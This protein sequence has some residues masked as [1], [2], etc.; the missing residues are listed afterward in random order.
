MTATA[1]VPRPA[2]GDQY[3][4]R[5]GDATAV[6]G[7]VAAVLREFTKAGV[8]YTETWPDEL[9]PPMGC[10]IVMAPWPNRIEDGR[11][12]DADGHEQQLDITEPGRNCA[13]HGLLRNVAFQPAVVTSDA[14][15]LAAPVPPQHGY[16][17]NLDVTV[18]YQLV[19]EGLRV[20]HTVTNR[21]AAPAPF[22]VGAHPYLRIGDVPVE[23]LTLAVPAD[24]QAPIDERW[25]PIGLAPV[26]QHG[27]DLRGA[28]RVLGEVNCDIALTDIAL[29]S[30]PAGDRH[31]FVLSAPDGRSLTLWSDPAFGW[32][33]LYT[34]PDFPGYG[35]DRRLAVAVE[36]MTCGANAFRTGKDVLT[37]QPG[38]T[39]SASWG[40]TPG[41]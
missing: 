34:P 19:A 4:L 16:P 22:G 26:G 9:I 33:Q 8:G 3:V 5:S 18:R 36:P 20:T 6:V 24:T 17:Y 2:S 21:G 40:L 10:G 12:T 41:Q 11:W 7:Q 30:S 28:G 13:I 37:V 25:I 38:E 35:D 15:T 31:E 29:T 14:V 1:F 32:V 27:P 39:W 23:Q